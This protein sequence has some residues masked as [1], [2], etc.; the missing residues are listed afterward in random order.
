MTADIHMNEFFT[1]GGT[2]PADAPSYVKR[3]TD[4]ELFRHIMSG[5][6]CYVLT[7]RQMGKSSL[8]IR[9]SQRLMNAGVRTAVVDL[10]QIG[11]VQSEDQWYKG[12]LTQIK[13]RLKLHIEPV[14]WWEERK[15]IP[16][17][18]KF[19]EFFEEALVPVKEHIVIFIDEIDTTLKLDFRDNFFAGIRAIFNGR[20]E[21]PDFKRITFVLLGVASPSDLIK[22]RNRTPFNIGQEILLRPF[23]REDARMLEKG[24]EDVYPSYGK[25]ILDRVFYWTNGHPYLT[26]KLCQSIVESR[27]AV[28]SDA[29]IDRLVKSLFTS[30]VASRETNLQFV[31]DNVLSYP[32]RRVILS[33][34]KKILQGRKVL[35]NKNSLPQNHLRLSGLVRIE[36]GRLVVSNNIYCSVFDLTWVSKYVEV[37]WRYWI[38]AVLSLMVIGFTSIFYNDV[39]RL[40][41]QAATKVNG[42]LIYRD[43]RG[44]QY[45]AELFR[46]KPLVFSNEYEY[47]AKDAF[48]NS[49]GTWE[50]Q[51]AMIEVAY[52]E[53]H[54][55]AE[56][57]KIVVEGLY[58]SL[59]D[60]DRTGETT[61]LLD[62]MYR[63]LEEMNLTNEDLFREIGYWLDA[64][65][66]V[67][68]GDLQRAIA[69]YS[70]A[71]E[72]NPQNPATL[73][74]R[75]RIYAVLGNYESALVDYE[76]I[77]ALVPAS[78]TEPTAIP[79]QEI[80]SATEVTEFTP[81]A[82]PTT[83]VTLAVPSSTP[84]PIQSST[85]N[86][87]TV[88]AT[89]SPAEVETKTSLAATSTQPIL[90][91]ATATE[92][93]FPADSPSF[94]GGER[95]I[96]SKFLTRGQRIAAVRNAI[97]QDN[98][99]R[100]YFLS[101]PELV[102]QYSRL[103][104]NGLINRKPT[105]VEYF[106][107]GTALVAQGVGGQ[108]VLDHQ[109]TG[110]A[111][112]IKPST[113]AHVSCQSARLISLRRSPGFAD[114]DNATDV[115]LQIP[116][117]EK[118]LLLEGPETI[119]NVEWW[120]AVFN[121]T[122]GWIPQNTTSDR[123]ILVIPEVVS[124]SNI[125]LQEDF[126]DGQADGWPKINDTLYFGSWVVKQEQNGNHYW[127]GSGTTDYPQIWYGEQ[128][129]GWADYVIENR[130]KFV[131]A[132]P[133]SGQLFIC[134]RTDAGGAFYTVYINTG[135][136]NYAEYNVS[137]NVEWTTF[138]S[139]P[140]TFGIGVW[141]TVDVE[142]KD[143]ILSTYVD[144]QLII[145]EPLPEPI[146]NTQGGIGYYMGGGDTFYIDDIRVWLLKPATTLP[147]T[148]IPTFAPADT[149]VYVTTDRVGEREIYR[150]SNGVLR[151]TDAADGIESWSPITDGS[152][153]LYFV[154]NRDGKMEIY[155]LRSDSSV[156]RVTYTEGE[157]ESWSPAVSANGNL[158]F[159]SDRE[160]K[161]DIYR[162]IQG[163]A[164][165]VTESP[166]QSESW[167]PAV[168]A[169]GDLFFVS[170]RDGKADIY[171]LGDG[172]V[173]KVISSP[174][175]SESWSP[176][177]AAD[178]NLY[179]T[180]N[181]DGKAEIYMLDNQ[182]QVTQITSS[183]GE[184]QSWSPVLGADGSLYFTSN[185]NAQ[186]TE[187]FVWSDGA[188]Y[189]IGRFYDSQNWTGTIDEGRYLNK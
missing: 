154:S 178:G 16:Q 74:E 99:F 171:K 143:N 142:V 173:V 25:K 140:T 91:T 150:I 185:R 89:P 50:E 138:A 60:V 145:S 33:L 10:A 81:P 120:Y 78:S 17:V 21:N 71:I 181:R 163:R 64:R 82:T 152:G 127:S 161:A 102:S 118:V 92:E 160:G 174:G 122:E 170:N 85:A 137:K 126:E 167:S 176:A 9:T 52:G 111:L 180:S 187:V 113:I 41:N 12:V 53:P 98:K 177:P 14:L 57:Y 29:E 3:P 114:K 31:R 4:D 48:F 67:D 58:T 96:Q 119:D 106:A 72:I 116:C 37:D 13:R 65:K 144:G 175:Q 40:P 93:A 151:I 129:T 182:G 183:P 130:I 59:A 84:R 128:F 107:T 1:A 105:L 24:L 26:Q 76:Q 132:A 179:F 55:P 136:V 101:N 32:E 117:G 39:V 169:N 62:V 108:S 47:Q 70:G 90:N 172:Q 86:P 11:T 56:D 63:S 115:I 149:D 139:S 133:D 134:I 103:E 2:L 43:D 189:G 80:S 77:I 61:R 166:G 186:K 164:E 34:Y 148:P 95:P 73:F 153:N 15:D 38:I 155:I 20:A 66:N 69:S 165:R 46:M 79:T 54:P 121:G 131:E 124:P 7:P 19:I 135:S 168:S 157:A 147:S 22:D 30:D 51:R 159:T 146:I 109:A 125:V 44:I 36:E 18:Q 123:T 35:E 49:L 5:E 141:Y 8:M 87:I 45:L 162:L 83:S 100:L 75:A 42:M 88:S 97:N 112:A 110:T 6:F 27:S 94:P 28:Y 23:S 188:I 68:E 184:S 156:T 104:E 158:Y